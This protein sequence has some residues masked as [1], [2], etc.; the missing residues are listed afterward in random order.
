MK[1]TD[2]HRNISI[3]AERNEAKAKEKRNGKVIMDFANSQ[4]DCYFA[5]F[6]VS[7]LHSTKA[8]ERICDGLIVF[9][10][11]CVNALSAVQ[12]VAAKRLDNVSKSIHFHFISCVYVSSVR[13]VEYRE[14]ANEIE[15]P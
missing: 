14:A 12:Y 3:H 4:N 11:V 1:S 13:T 7:R 5:W 8:N 15:Y 6:T 2:D 10:C 9:A